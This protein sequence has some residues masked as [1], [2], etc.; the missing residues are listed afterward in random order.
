MRKILLM[1]L[2]LIL[3]FGFAACGGASEEAAGDDDGQNP[4][5]NFIGKYGCYRATI[6]VEAEGADGAK[7]TVTWS[8]SAAENSE[9]V[10]SGTFDSETLAVK[11]DDCV[12]T[13]Y[14]YDE[15]GEVIS[16]EEQ[17]AGGSG[18]I[19]FIDG[20]KLALTWQDDQENIAEGMTFE[21]ASYGGD[22]SEE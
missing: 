16:Q 17:Y 20:D 9:W 2:V 4:V 7:F 3:C 19:Q 5:M 8:S 1:I 14:V 22:D 18:T 21:Y 13:N 12:R 10:M 6:M 15:N 11:Y